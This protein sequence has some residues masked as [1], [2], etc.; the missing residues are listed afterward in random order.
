MS[1]LGSEKGSETNYIAPLC[2]VHSNIRW[3]IVGKEPLCTWRD[4]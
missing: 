3:F 1:F 2:I 4:V